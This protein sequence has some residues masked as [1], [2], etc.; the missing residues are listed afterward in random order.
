MDMRFYW[1]QD[2][3]RQDYF[4][5]FW[6][7]G[8]VNL[9]DYFTKHHPPHRHIEMRP[10]YL[11]TEATKEKASVRVFLLLAA[12]AKLCNY[13]ISGIL[14]C[15]GNI[16]PKARATHRQATKKWDKIPYAQL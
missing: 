16:T 5:V 4:H 7:P 8:T 12:T 1:I 10:I 14:K 13:N 9:G 15:D 6:K 11:H 3:I 2:R